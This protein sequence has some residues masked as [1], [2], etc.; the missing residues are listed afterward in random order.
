[1]KLNKVLIP[2]SKALFATHDERFDNQIVIIWST[3]KIVLVE[4]QMM[5]IVSQLV[6]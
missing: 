2:R 6:V 5:K 3:L 1:M 4:L